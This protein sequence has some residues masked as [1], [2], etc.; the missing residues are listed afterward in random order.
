VALVRMSVPV[1]PWQEEHVQCVLY[2]VL[3]VSILR[4][5]FTAIPSA[6]EM[7]ARSTRMD[8]TKAFTLAY[9]PDLCPDTHGLE[10]RISVL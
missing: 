7:E 6:S 5:A 10:Q 4:R 1:K 9:V 2:S 8:L 3:M